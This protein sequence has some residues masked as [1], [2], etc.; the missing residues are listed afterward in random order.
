MTR[1]STNTRSWQNRHSLQQAIFGF[2]AMS[3]ISLAVGIASAQNFRIF[4]NKAPHAAPPFTHWDLREFPNCAVPWA[5]GAGLVPDLDGNGIANVADRAIFID[6]CQKGFDRWDGIPGCSELN[7]TNLFAGGLPAGG[8]I[9]DNFNTLSFSAVALGPTVTAATVVRRSAVTGRITE[10]D[11]VFNSNAAAFMVGANL[12]VG[13]RQWV[14]KAHGAV[15]VADVDLP[16]TGNWP[17]VA[18][19]DTDVDGDGVQDNEVDLGTTATHEIGHFTG[20]DHTTPLVSAYNDPAS[21]MMN[22]FWGYGLG[23]NNSGWTNLTLKDPDVDGENFLYCPDM[24]DAPDP[25]MGVAGLYPSRVSIPQAGRT[26]NGLLLN[27]VGPGA[28]HI[29]G[30]KPLQP[31]NWTYEWLGCPG[32]TN[33]VDSEWEANI[34]DKDAFDDGVSFFPNPPVWG[35]PLGVIAWAQYASDNAGNR[36]AGALFANSW[37]DLNQDCV[38]NNFGIEWFMR[39]S[40]TPVAPSGVFMFKTF[41]QLPAFVPYPNLPVWLRCRLDHA[42]NVGQA[43]NIDGTLAFTAGAAQFGEVEDYPFWCNTRYE[44]IWVQNTTGTTVQGIAM[45]TVGPDQ[46]PA[47]T[48]AAEVDDNDCILQV[49][50][51]GFHFTH[52]DGLADET[53][54]QF[55]NPTQVPPGKK[56]H[57]GKCKPQPNDNL[58]LARAYWIPGGVAA[59]P[60]AI[61]SNPGSAFWIPTVNCGL[62]FIWPPYTP[63]SAARVTVGALDAGTGGFICGTVA[64]DSLSM[65]W[66]DA[67]LVN[68]S[69]RVANNL[70]PLPNLSPCDPT[71]ASLPIHPVGAGTVTP[72]RGLVFDVPVPGLLAGKYLIVEVESR[73]SRNGTISHQISEFPTP[74]PTST[75]GRT[76]PP[77]R[78]ALSNFPNPFNPNTTIHVA[79]PEATI[80]SLQVYDVNGA[81]VRTLVRDAM[82]PEGV[83]EVEWNGRN[84]AGKPVSSGVYFYRLTT[85][86]ETLTRKAVLLK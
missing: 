20:L 79:L 45:V 81:L 24:G 64:P 60:R 66:D 85:G 41:V 32:G 19:G 36:H 67:L 39:Q 25:W 33:N 22:Q 61:E 8:F 72:E 14:R 43:A 84:D 49:I 59:E 57:T 1:K 63:V 15:C 58:T 26:L 44:Q 4:P 11:I 7:F 10:A 27:G 21:P 65:Q 55:I 53:V 77:A 38:W 40:R 70:I 71:Y 82:K 23:P 6:E 83:F 56:H 9:M 80:V 46:V 35:R 86:K 13:P 73:W 68:V 30:I 50:P 28:Q 47:Q 74:I 51:P 2:L 17:T 75:E 31:R 12:R 69:F 42:E 18:D 16:P 29:F 54:T 52:Y 37:I 3:T 34:V 76:P 5:I 48:W 78:L 62:C